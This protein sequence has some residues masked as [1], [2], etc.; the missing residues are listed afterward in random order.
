MKTWT[1]LYFVPLLCALVVMPARAQSD[2]ATNSPA[3]AAPEPPPAPP[4]ETN[5]AVL[6]KKARQRTSPGVLVQPGSIYVNLPNPGGMNG[7]DFNENFLKLAMA[8]A[9]IFTPFICIVF[10]C[11]LILYYRYR[12]NKMLHDTLRMMIEKGVPIPPELIVPPERTV[13][14]KT[15][16]DLRTGLVWIAIG[17]GVMVLFAAMQFRAW[18]IGFIFVL[19][20]AAFL[21]AWRVEKKNVTNN[22]VASK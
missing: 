8:L 1:K 19:M 5:A 2:N 7:R 22:E 4:A 3:I 14:R 10:V 12:R 9:A 6:A 15:R 13:K 17:F 21:I 16:S 20:G 18:P 11:G